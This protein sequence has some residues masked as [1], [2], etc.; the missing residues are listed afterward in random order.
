MNM[1]SS[2]SKVFAIGHPQI[3]ELFSGEVFVEE[4]VDGS[5]FSFGLK[6]GKLTMRSNGCDQ[7]GSDGDKLFNLARESVIAV[8]DKLFNGFVYR[9]EYFS[10]PKHNTIAYDRIPRNHIMIFDIDTTG[11]NNYMLYDAKKDEAERLGFECVPLLYRGVVENLDRIKSFL[12][13]DSVLGGSKVEGVVCKNYDRWT[14]DGK[15]MMGKFVSEAFKEKNSIDWKDRNP[16]RK[17]V[18]EQIIEEYKT[19]ARW[20]K[21][22]QHL[23]ERG[24][25]HDD[26]SDIGALIKEIG[27]DFVSECAEEI[28]ARLFLHFEKA[29]VVGIRRG[30]PEWYKER[31]AK[32]AF[33]VVGGPENV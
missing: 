32:Y 26:P 17:D 25:V 24:L 6:D 11:Q 14:R 5:Q 31:I 15:T 27:E 13:M 20:E 8:E 2:Y 10:K 12:D 22:I 3:Q 33:D 16:G 1:L 19:E 28:G 4:K 29:L 30:F 18:I 7:T 23:R 9:G 21:A